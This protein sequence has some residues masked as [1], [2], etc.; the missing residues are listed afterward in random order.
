MGKEIAHHHYI[1]KGGSA[2]VNVEVLHR[3]ELSCNNAYSWIAAQDIRYD[4]NFVGL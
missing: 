4:A 1:K 3:V 2:W